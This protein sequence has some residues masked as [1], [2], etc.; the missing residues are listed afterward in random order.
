MLVNMEVIVADQMLQVTQLL[1]HVW[2]S[3]FD[4]IIE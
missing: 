3:Y 4:I 1:Y 2:C